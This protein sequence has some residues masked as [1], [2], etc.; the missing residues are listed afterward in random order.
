M[1][2][3]EIFKEQLMACFF[4]DNWFASLE[5]ALKDLTEEQASWKQEEN[6]HSIWEIMNHLVFYNSRHLKL[7][8]K[9]P[10]SNSHPANEDTFIIKDGDNWHDQKEKLF[11]VIKEW[12]EELEKL[13]EGELLSSVREDNKEP[14]IS[15]LLN[16]TIHNASHVGQIILIRK[17]QGSWKKELS[18]S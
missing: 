5:T 3:N 8:K 7:F 13:S 12:I 16:V 10:L 14:W 2:S 11:L 4:E 1:N 9:E 18:V 17:L 6:I 15:V